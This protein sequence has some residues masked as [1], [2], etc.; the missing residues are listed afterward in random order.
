L[1]REALAKE[2]QAA[3]QRAKALQEEEGVAARA[4]HSALVAAAE[5]CGVDPGELAAEVQVEARLEARLAA[6]RAVRPEKEWKEDRKAGEV[7]RWLRQKFNRDGR[8]EVAACAHSTQRAV[9][10]FPQAIWGWRF[11]N[12]CAKCC[13]RGTLTFLLYN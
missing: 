7:V 2:V 11:G 10:I 4:F 3:E 12:W 6:A 5:A 1:A 13:E 9:L 8:E